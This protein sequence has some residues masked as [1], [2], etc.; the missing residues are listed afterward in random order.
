MTFY[1]DGKSRLVVEAF[2]A[3]LLRLNSLGYRAL[4]G[5]VCGKK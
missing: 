1:L 5:T 4:H 3:N 2:F